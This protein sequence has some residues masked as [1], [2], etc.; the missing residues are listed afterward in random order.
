[1]KMFFV[2]TQQDLI[3][4]VGKLQNALHERAEIGVRQQHRARIANS[5]NGLHVKF[6]LKLTNLQKYNYRGSSSICKY[7]VLDFIL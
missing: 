1:M 6:Q 7:L 2:F 5:L 3:D 4:K